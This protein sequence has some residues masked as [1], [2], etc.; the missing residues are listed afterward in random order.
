[1]ELKGEMEVPHRD[2]RTV[3]VVA[4]AEISTEIENLDLLADMLLEIH[5]VLLLPG[6][7]EG[8]ALTGYIG[9]IKLQLIKEDMQCQVTGKDPISTIPR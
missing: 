1:M 6:E 9:E 3:I 4:T 2:L 5:R 7:I 8:E